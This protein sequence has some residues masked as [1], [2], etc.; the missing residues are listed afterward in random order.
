MAQR[1]ILLVDD[2]PHI[3]QVL[4][5]K[6]RNAGYEVT[7][8]SDG[9]EAL[10][11][12]TSTIPDLVITDV[13]MPYMNG[14][15]LCRGLAADPSTQSVPVILLTARGYALDDSDV[16]IGNIRDVVSKPFSPR[17]VLLRIEQILGGDAGTP[18]QS[19]KNPSSEAA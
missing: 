4:A 10:E 2:E 7:T 5:I 15:E 18:E 16:E 14:V 1:R 8:A 11:M 13:Q 6:L 12:A 19:T 17:S 3:L 9:E